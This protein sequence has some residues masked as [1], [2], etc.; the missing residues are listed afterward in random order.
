MWLYE[1]LVVERRPLHPIFEASG[2]KAPEY[3]RAQ[4]KFFGCKVDFVDGFIWV[5]GGDDR[6]GDQAIAQAF[7]L[8]VHVP[9]VRAG[10]FTAE[11]F[12]TLCRKIQADARVADRKINPEFVEAAVKQGGG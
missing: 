12:I 4:S 3:D 2:R 10:R 11:G 9:V 7:E 1:K 6:D 5:I 8:I